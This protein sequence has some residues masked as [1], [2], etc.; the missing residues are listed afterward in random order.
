M[1]A[2]PARGTHSSDPSDPGAAELVVIGA[3]GLLGAEV[4]A[5]AHRRGHRV[6]ALSR[7]DVDITEPAAVGALLDRL[8][9]AVVLNAAAWTDVDGCEDDP[10]RAHRINAEAVGTLAEACTRRGIRLVHLSTD[11][12]FGGTA[13]TTPAGNRRGWREDDPPAPVNA[14]GRSKLA[15]EVRVREAGAD[16]LV[17]RTAWLSGRAGGFVPRVLEAARH[18]VWD[19][20]AGPLRGVVDR[21]GSPTVAGHLAVALLDVA[22]RGDV[23]GTLHLAGAGAATWFDLACQ[24][25]GAAGLDVEVHACTASR[26]PQRAARPA[27]SVLGVERCLGLG[28]ALPP[29]QDQVRDLVGELVD[30]DTSGRTPD[31]VDDPGRTPQ[32]GGVGHADMS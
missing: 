13:L 31:A 26:F 16:H 25:V 15:G 11:Y 9:P 18:R 5:A 4:V 14:Y 12:V 27:W 2:Y 10:A 21:T 30:D 6:R 32:R 22:G 28:L 24:V 17:V 19:P 3:A 7:A 29:W 8:R 1:A 23:T 20:G